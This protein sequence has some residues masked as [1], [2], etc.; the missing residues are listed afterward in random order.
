M[1]RR[2][3]FS[4]LRPEDQIQEFSIRTPIS[5]KLIFAILIPNLTEENIKTTMQKALYIYAHFRSEI[6][7][8]RLMSLV[9][10]PA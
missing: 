5:K 4:H 10:K 9:G 8:G 1:P 3:K 7:G 2:P 6:G